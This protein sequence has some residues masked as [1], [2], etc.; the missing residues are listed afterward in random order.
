MTTLKTKLK[1]FSRVAAGVAWL[2]RYGP[3]G[4]DQ[5]LNLAVLR[6]ESVTSCPLAQIFGSFTAGCHRLC[7]TLAVDYECIDIEDYGFTRATHNEAWCTMLTLRAA[8]RVSGI[9]S[10]RRTS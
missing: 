8:A 7:Q 5:K 1:T 10:A 6:C 9:A 4:W 3:P 2:D